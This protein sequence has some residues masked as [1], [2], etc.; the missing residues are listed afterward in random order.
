MPGGAGQKISAQSTAR[1]TRRRTSPE[2]QATLEAAFQHN[3][4]PDKTARVELAHKVTM[5]EK[6]ISIWFQN[7]RQVSRR[8]SRPGLTLTAEEI[9]S[10]LQSSQSDSAECSSGSNESSSQEACQSS[11]S[12]T[13][14]TVQSTAGS[15]RQDLP[16]EGN[17]MV[18]TFKTP[19]EQAAVCSHQDPSAQPILNQPSSNSPTNGKSQTEK[20]EKEKP[21]PL[22]IH[23]PASNHDD[24]PLPQKRSSPPKKSDESVLTPEDKAQALSSDTI[25]SLPASLKR[26][27]SQPRLCTSLDGSVRVKT[28]LSPT[29]SPPRSRITNGLQPRMTGPL[30]RSQ[31]AM[32]PSASS[33]LIS[34][35][36]GRSRDSRTWEFFCDT[37]SRNALT[38]AAELE[39]TGSAAGAIA[40]IRSASSQTTPTAA[41][42][43]TSNKRSSPLIGRS[44]SQKRVKADIAKATSKPQLARTSSSVARLQ[45]NSNASNIG[46]TAQSRVKSINATGSEN[47]PKK[48]TYPVDIYVDG[49]DSDKENW[50]PGSQV[51]APTRR[52]RK[53]RAPPISNILRENSYLSSQPT[54]LTPRGFRGMG[55]HGNRLGPKPYEESDVSDDDNDD[56]EV[57]RFMGRRGTSGLVLGRGGDEED[58]AGVHGLLSL[59]QG[60]WR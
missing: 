8:R 19:K 25:R 39:Q 4:K 13:P 31:S 14:D 50:V 44:D 43:P 57:A 15:E 38:R 59:S 45:T 29:P 37:T 10:T 6:E 20:S 23:Q 16:T 30:Q 55:R 24:E 34:S 9:S 54:S 28:G 41:V 48:K 46:K 49:N 33:T 1:Q 3:S 36:F 5:G 26:T 11:Q 47:N 60:A 21:V 40:L 27:L 58:M 32:L 35:N 7:K 12:S 56:E 17:K 22:S 52:S 42:A 53:A 2:D 18:Q 51:S